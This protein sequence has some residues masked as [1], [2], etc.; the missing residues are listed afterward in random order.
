[1]KSSHSEAARLFTAA[2]EYM[3]IAGLE[4]EIT[5]QRNLQLEKFSE[6]D[7][8]R[9]GAW[10]ILCSGFREATV[11]RVFDHLSLCFFDW[12]SAFEISTNAT[13]CM[14]AARGSFRNEQ[15]LS[16]IVHLAELVNLSGF[17]KLKER[18]LVNPIDELQIIPF[19]GPTTAWH[20]AKNL[21]LDSSK[22]D[23]HLLRAASA[24]G[25][26]SPFALCDTVSKMF[27]EQVRVV[28]LILW[29]YLADNP[30]LRV[31]W[32]GSDAVPCR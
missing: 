28:D 1:M 3:S 13:T 30:S 11:R 17:E 25:F 27:N 6:A 21:G 2:C 14:S 4:E 5:W 7:L 20:L 16:A 24:L 32:S 15:K 31:A 8:L 12:E 19:I 29:R 23:R 26:G 22:P 10:V 9:E 18:I